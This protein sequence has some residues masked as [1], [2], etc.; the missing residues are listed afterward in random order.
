MLRALTFF[1]RGEVGLCRVDLILMHWIV[2]WCTLSC[3]LLVCR[4]R[5]EV[6]LRRRGNKGKRPRS[7]SATATQTHGSIHGPPYGGGADL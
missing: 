7:P 2:V 3:T 1:L 6:G 5:C 4:Y